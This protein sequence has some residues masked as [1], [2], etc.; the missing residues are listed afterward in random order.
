M[1]VLIP[2]SRR[3]SGNINNNHLMLAV[4]IPFCAKKFGRSQKIKEAD[5]DATKVTVNAETSNRLA[6]KTFAAK[7]IAASILSVKIADITAAEEVKKASK[8]KS[9]VV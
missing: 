1:D 8:E 2:L 5:I 4:R 3:Q 9:A 6:S 7:G